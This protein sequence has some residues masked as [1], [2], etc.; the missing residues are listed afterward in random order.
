M[1]GVFIAEKRLAGVFLL[2]SSRAFS[3]IPVSPPVNITNNMT[4]NI[5]SFRE[6]A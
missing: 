2:S 4:H 1:H 5:E 6:D 3:R